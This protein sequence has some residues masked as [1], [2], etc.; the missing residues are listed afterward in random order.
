MLKQSP[1]GLSL[2]IFEIFFF[3]FLVSRR[4]L[5]V[6]RTVRNRIEEMVINDSSDQ[7]SFNGALS[8]DKYLNR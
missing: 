5:A 8:A 1:A 3:L 2:E 7:R 6:E 4:T